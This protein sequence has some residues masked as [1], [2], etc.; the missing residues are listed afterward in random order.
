MSS[1]SREVRLGIVMFGGVSLAVYINGV[2]QELFRAVRGRGVYRLIKALTDSEIV[3]DILSGASAGGINSVL[4][5]AALCNETELGDVATLWRD[6]ADIEPLLS[7]TDGVPNDGSQSKRE[8]DSIFD[9]DYHDE[10]LKSAIRCLLDTSR[11]RSRE[12]EDPSK[13]SELDLFVTGTDIDGRKPIWVDALGRK[14]QLEEHRTLFH[15]KHRPAHDNTPFASKAM[16]F[17]S[18]KGEPGLLETNVE[19][20]AKVSH[21]TSCFPGAFKPK[22][23]IVPPKL[24]TKEKFVTPE[25]GADARVS[26]W[27][28]LVDGQPRQAIFMDGGVLKNK[29][30]TSTIEAIFSRLADRQVSRYMLY[31]EPDAADIDWTQP[32]HPEHDDPARRLVPVAAAAL[33][34]LPRFES[35]VADLDQVELHNQ[36]VR[37]YEVLIK[38]A[39]AAALSGSAVQSGLGTPTWSAYRRARITGLAAAVV[40]AALPPA[41]DLL[42]YRAPPSATLTKLIEQL[43]ADPHLEQLFGEFDVL[44]P[45]RRLIHLNYSIDDNGDVKPGDHGIWTRI[46]LPTHQ[47]RPEPLPVDREVMRTI[48]R[49]IEFY[50][51]VRARLEHE[52]EAVARRH[53]LPPPG[54]VWDDEVFWG[55]LALHLRAVLQRLP[56]PR[57]FDPNVGGM[58]STDELAELRGPKSIGAEPEQ[59]VSGSESES[60]SNGQRGKPLLCAAKEFEQRVLANSDLGKLYD[61]FP[62][63]D[64]V[65]YPIELASELRGRDQIRTVR[66]SPLDSKGGLVEGFTE[67]LC[68]RQLFAFGA[69]FKAS[70]RANDL[71]WGRLDGVSQL[72]ELLLDAKRLKCLPYELLAANLTEALGESFDLT[73][74]FPHS[75]EAERKLLEGWLRNVASHD[76]HERARARDALTDASNFRSRWVRAAQLEVIVEELPLVFERAANEA[77]ANGDKEEEASFRA[78]QAQLTDNR[79]STVGAAALAFFTPKHYGIAHQKLPG[80]IPASRLSAIAHQGGAHLKEA[81]LASLPAQT[82]AQRAVREA[83][84]VMLSTAL[85]L[86]TPYLIRKDRKASTANGGGARSARVADFFRSSRV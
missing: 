81:L 13:V 30:F 80:A 69:F 40:E 12:K 26:Y 60:D 61:V 71:M 82:L 25:A 76:E 33:S 53:Q 2:S 79:P 14:V 64:A 50:E 35:I 86:A 59:R 52:V 45:F 84:G 56:V 19:A 73:P 28:G 36:K 29:P 31:I 17:G 7:L 18:P 74:I 62:Q 6:E 51:A 65:A 44:F 70:W 54:S 46:A 20:L 58:V 3:V 10:K 21:I 1:R 85:W 8:K 38:E 27:G 75:P 83:V 78:Q 47:G 34:G 49:Q 32:S 43:S 4:L 67:K 5:S 16:C 42:P 63:I 9:G 72:L 57:C 55:K 41:A 11:K 15:L 68:G 22:R 39:T 37:R 66:I 77:A 23:V 48:N 24:S